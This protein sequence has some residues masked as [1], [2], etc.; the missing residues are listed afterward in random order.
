MPDFT[1]SLSKEISG[2][3]MFRRGLWAGRHPFPI[4]GS[5]VHKFGKQ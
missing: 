3:N 5:V 1:Q 2:Q 4:A